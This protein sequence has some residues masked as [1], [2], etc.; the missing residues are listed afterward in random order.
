MEQQHLELHPITSGLTTIGGKNGDSFSAQAPLE[1]LASINGYP[2]VLAAEYGE[3]KVVIL[4]NEFAFY[5]SGFT[6]DIS[7]GDHDQLV[8]NIWNWL[9]E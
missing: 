8:Q 4:N 3:G 7:Y 9:L 6:Y 1:V 2:F 5:N